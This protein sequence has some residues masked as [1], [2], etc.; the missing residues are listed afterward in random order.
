MDTTLDFAAMTCDFGTAATLGATVV[1]GILDESPIDAYGVVGGNSPIFVI[2]TSDLAT[3]PRGTT[4]TVE[5]R[6][7]TVRD[8]I[9]DG[10]G[11]STLQ[12]ER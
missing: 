11:V 9:N 2:K 12:L 5:T 10:T 7:F 4:L 1:R 6:A 3:D 8:W